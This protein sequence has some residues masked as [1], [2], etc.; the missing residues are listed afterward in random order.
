MVT[1]G[2]LEFRRSAAPVGRLEFGM[3]GA[4]KKEGAH[5]PA[6]CLWPLTIVMT[7]VTIHGSRIFGAFGLQWEAQ[8]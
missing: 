5:A 6:R 3:I 7:L 8:R 1:I 2:G 4:R